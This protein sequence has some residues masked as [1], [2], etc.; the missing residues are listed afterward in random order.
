MKLINKIST[1][2]L[3][4]FLFWF[5]ESCIE[6]FEKTVPAGTSILVVENITTDQ[7]GDHYVA[8][9]K[10]VT[11]GIS[12]Y[13]LF[14]NGAEVQILVNG[15]QT[16]TLKE[17]EKGFYYFPANFKA[18]KN[19]T[20]QLKFKLANGQQYESGLESVPN[21]APVIKKVYQEF[22]FNDI[23]LTATKKVPGHNIYIDYDD[24]ANETNYYKLT[25][26]LWESQLYCLTCPSGTRFYVGKGC[27]KD[28]TF[29][30]VFYDYRCDNYCWEIIPSRTI[31][32]NNDQINNGKSVL[33]KLAAQ[34]PLY[35][36]QP[37][38]LRIE[39][40]SITLNNY[41]YLKLLAQ[42]SQ[43][44]GGLADTPPAAIVGN[45]RNVNN[46]TE[47]IVGYFSITSTNN[48]LYKLDRKDAG[49][50]YFLTLLGR[51]AQ[52]EPT[53]V[54]RPPYTPCEESRTRTGQKPV[55]W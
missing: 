28:G 40:A 15:S 46:S 21:K 29:A 33:A 16:L 23:P 35:Q 36:K 41:Q 8:I 42:Q 2:F 48:A 37:A 24:A 11:Q 26:T 49:P 20:Y 45:V 44:N 25:W 50:S 5:C 43:N 51:E 52:E 10:A 6:P 3:F 22:S 12:S 32:I 30:N 18:E 47:P 4:C 14:E 19:T 38:L 54:D 1:C 9:K 27:V 13:D 31:N 34:V 7:L 53:T 17:K 39:L 55:G